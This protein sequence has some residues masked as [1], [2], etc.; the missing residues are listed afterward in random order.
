MPGAGLLCLDSR[1]GEGIADAVAIPLM[2]RMAGKREE[3]CIL[4]VWDVNAVC[5]V[6][7]E[8]GLPGSSRAGCHVI[9]T[10]PHV[11]ALHLAYA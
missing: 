7:S 1:K 10:S 9:W 2:A 3:R 5:C 11:Q 4:L 8:M 6:K